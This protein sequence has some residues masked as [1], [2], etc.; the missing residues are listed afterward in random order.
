M[1][2][3]TLLSLWN[4]KNPTQY[5]QYTT[6]FE[7]EMINYM[8]NCLDSAKQCN[9]MCV[10]FGA[11]DGISLSNTKHLL[12][13]G[14]SGVQ[15]EPCYNKYQKLNSL[16]Q[17]RLETVKCI[18]RAV[19][20]ESK[21]TDSFDNIMADLFL[22]KPFLIDI[23]SIDVDGPDYQ[24]FK[25]IT[26]YIPKIILV[27]V[28]AHVE[29]H[30]DE[31]MTSMTKLA[32]QKGYKLLAYT[33]NLIFCHDNYFSLMQLKEVTPKEA[34]DEYWINLDPLTKHH[35]NSTFDINTYWML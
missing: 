2:T 12:D 22:W 29:G 32:N 24:I 1:Q 4:Y 3:K 34:W 8:V 13:K 30:T 35:V 31:G 28:N 9:N 20:V 27:E 5:G 21:S 25:T 6:P 14:W 33:G 26:K 18:N 7:T 16:Y 17:D 11:A 15:I 19:S 10:E 23:L